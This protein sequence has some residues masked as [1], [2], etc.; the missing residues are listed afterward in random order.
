M[1]RVRDRL[2][3]LALGVIF[4][5][6]GI[7]MIF[8]IVED[9]RFINGDF[10]SWLEAEAVIDDCR[11]GIVDLTRSGKEYIYT[12]RYEY[13]VSFN[14]SMGWVS[15]ENTADNQVRQTSP[16][17]TIDAF[18]QIASG[19]AGTVSYDPENPEDFR[20]GSKDNIA[21]AASNPMR[22]LFCIVLLAGSGLVMWLA[23]RPL[24]RQKE[25]LAWH[26]IPE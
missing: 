1:I 4:V 19:N 21:K 5:A 2:I 10:V 20:W 22:I 16:D 6:F 13:T 18:Q 8:T 11:A 26:E 17:L 7:Y 24:L 23:I 3:L 15:Y 25:K 14:T 12:I 9:H